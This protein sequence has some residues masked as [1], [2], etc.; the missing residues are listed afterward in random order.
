MATAITG[1]AAVVFAAGAGPGSGPERKWTIDAG[2]AMRLVEAAEVAG[3]DRYVMVSS[4]G[5][6][7]P[8]DGDDTWSVYLQAKAKADQKLALSDLAWTIVRP[9]FMNDD[10]GRGLVTIDV[11]PLEGEISRDDVAATLFDVLHVPRTAHLTLY[12][13]AGDTPVDKALGAVL[14]TDK[15]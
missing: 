9:V 3:V 15:E 11:T 5:A 13:A 1:A 14:T 8:P 6:E 10:P 12:V 4:I 7:D 2:A